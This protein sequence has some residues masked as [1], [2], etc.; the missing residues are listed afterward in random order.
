MPNN[1]KYKLFLFIVIFILLFTLFFNGQ[2]ATASCIEPGTPEE[3]FQRSDAVFTGSVVY[4]SSANVLWMDGIT[5]ILMAMGFHPADFYDTL[6]P[7]RRIVFQVDRSWKGVDTSSVMI[8]TGYNSEDSSSYPF[9]IGSYY[10]VYASHAYG[11]PDKYLL[12]S[13]CHST[14]RSPNNSEDIAYLNDLPLLDLRY[15]PA[16][17]RTIDGKFVTTLLVLMVIIYI[18]RRK[19]M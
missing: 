16:I 9:E 12:T 7:G 18:L 5:R 3:E 17:I 4:I 1:L 13:L 6:F 15:F 10:L 8:R 14:Q 11:D 19:K 2:I